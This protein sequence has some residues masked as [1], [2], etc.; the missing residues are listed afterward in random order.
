MKLICST[1]LLAGIIAAACSKNETPT[2]PTTT[3]ACAY[4]VSSTSLSPT[5]AGGTFS[6]T[7][8]RTSGACTWAASSNADWVTFSGASSASDTA[9]LTMI[10]APNASTS[11]RSGTVAVSWSGGNT[12]IA[13][14][15]AGLAF[16][17]CVYGFTAA[18]QTVPA[19]G[20]A[21]SAAL[22]VTGSGCAW[23]ASVDAAWLA[24]TSSVSGTASAAV[25]FTAAPNP[26]AT[27][28]AGT[29]TATYPGGS[30]KVTITQTGVST[31]TYTLSPSSQTVSS[32]GGSFSF[33]ATRNT[34]N[35]CS[36]SASTL[37]PWITLTG[38][39]SGLSGATIPYS[40]TANTDATRTG[41]ISVVW[42]GGSVDL[43]VTQ[44][45]ASGAAA[46]R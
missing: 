43:P 44:A 36:F 28:R 6:V 32:A 18:S 7:I 3:V 41:A 21:S 19:E 31:C 26:D 27:V 37:T 1:L 34:P 25:A 40:V 14:N 2:T 35:G 20:G 16:G 42:S 5:S 22:S 10:A 39:T 33:V 30:T 38:S 45:A 46:K 11:S 29:L 9:T 23:T 12:Q 24:I 13:V 8:T 4:T 15:Q 17:V